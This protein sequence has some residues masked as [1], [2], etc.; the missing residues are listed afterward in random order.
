MK[1]RR[2]CVTVLIVLLA[3][4]LAGAAA[5]AG[6]AAYGRH[7]MGKIPSMSFDDVLKYTTDGMPEAVIT[8]GFVKDGEASFSVYGEDGKLLPSESHTYE[9][10]SLTKTLT[11]ALACRAIGDGRLELDAGIDRYLELPEGGSYPTVKQLLTHTS[12]YKGYYF[13]TPM[14]GNHLG[15]KNDFLGITDEMVLKRLAG[16][17]PGK[18]VFNYSN[19]GYAALG[20]VLESVYGTEYTELVNSFASD[21]GLENTHVSD[22]SGDLGSYWDWKP[23]DAYISAGAITSDI[24]DMLAYA[25]MQ[26]DGSG[27]FGECHRSLYPIDATTESYKAMGINLDEIGMAWIIDRENGVIWHNGGTGD[28]NSYLGFKPDK[29]LAVVVLSNLSPNTRI[30]ATVLGIKLLNELSAGE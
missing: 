24:N 19:F 25:R 21:L 7:Q 11:A 10:G 8:V 15:G 27:C 17:K 2:K 20:L 13:E 3:L 16:V 22:G 12:G 4:I 5:L 29:G 28:Y 1:K 18:R 23:G 14:I 26:L 9:I 6:L 30:P